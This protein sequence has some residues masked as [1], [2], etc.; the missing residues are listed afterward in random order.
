MHALNSKARALLFLAL[1]TLIN[2]PLIF[3]AY[4][5]TDGWWE[6]YAWLVSLGQRP[7]QDFYL[8]FPPFFVMLQEWVIQ[9][10]GNNLISVRFIGFLSI[11][12]QLFILYKFLR[13]FSEPI[14]ALFGVA[15]SYGF[16]YQNG[17]YLVSDY[18][19]YV[20]IFGG[21][22]LL[23]VV[24]FTKSLNNRKYILLGIAGL[25]C[26]FLLLTKQNNGVFLTFASFI[27]I[28]AHNY[29][30]YKVFRLKF[31]GELS[32]FF[33][34]ITLPLSI[35]SFGLDL[36]WYTPYFDNDSKGSLSTVFLRF[37]LDNSIRKQLIFSIGF[38]LL[39][40]YAYRYFKDMR[41]KGLS[42]ELLPVG[43]IL[44]VY[45]VIFLVKGTIAIS[46]F[47]IT[48]VIF[49]RVIERSIVS[50]AEILVLM[51]ALVYCGTQSAGLN[52][53]SL[54]YLIAISFSETLHFF[55]KKFGFKNFLKITPHIFLLLIAGPKIMGNIGYEWWG[56]EAGRTITRQNVIEDFDYLRGV[57]TDSVTA[58]VIEELYSVKQVINENDTIF[59]YPSIPV[60]YKLLNKPPLF[61]LVHWFDVISDQQ[62]KN[63][64]ILLSEKA[65]D[66]I[67]WL[68]PQWSV[69][70][71]HF[72]LKRKIPFQLLIDD[73]IINQVYLNNYEVMS[74]HILGVNT[75]LTTIN[76]EACS[77]PTKL[78][79]LDAC[80]RD[81][82]CRIN[83]HELTYYYNTK[84]I[85][86]TSDELCVSSNKPIFYILK[87]NNPN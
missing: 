37:F 26:G 38:G 78:I 40:V 23:A 75:H 33:L 59:A 8:A 68:R 61:P 44:V 35:A 63:T 86:N 77:E 58:N 51:G 22:I 85:L 6:T 73:Y 54:E 43:L 64:L 60:I 4:S 66:Y 19:N 50:Y 55:I 57:S 9:L 10:F 79:L 41:F 65:P 62:I 82:S 20:S 74:G 47:A 15:I 48:W 3:N 81:S 87:K 1:V 21:L 28:F 46:M 49:R 83:A 5:L 56:Y 25:S 71:G 69:Y 32:V 27:V 11:V 14:S 45:F 36:L 42:L 16:I 39:G 80:K 29:V 52:I 31:I 72:R 2:L 76:V 7:Y 18:H 70:E 13:F 53:V 34:A 12:T 30:N 24:G 17:N 67:F 84:K